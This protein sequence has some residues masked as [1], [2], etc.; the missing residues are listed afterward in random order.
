[1][2][3][4]EEFADLP[5]IPRYLDTQKMIVIFEM[6]EFFVGIGAFMAVFFIGF[7]TGTTTAITMPLGLVLLIVSGLSVK[8]IKKRYPNGFIVHYMYRLGYKDPAGPAKLRREDLKR[9]NRVMPTGYVTY[10]VH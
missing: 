7:A 8:K 6:D 3:K 10:F 5:P 9:G 4:H 2:A 1:M